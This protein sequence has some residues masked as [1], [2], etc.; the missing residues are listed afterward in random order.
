MTIRAQI[1]RDYPGYYFI[2]EKKWKPELSLRD[3]SEI[4]E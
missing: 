3:F 4:T 1:L 2:D